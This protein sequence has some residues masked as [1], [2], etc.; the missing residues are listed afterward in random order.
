MFLISDPTLTT[1]NV[2]QVMELVNEWRSLSYGVFR[3]EVIIP[4]SQMSDI[5]Q[6]SST[7]S[8]ISTECAFHYVHCHPE[9]SWTHLARHLYDRGEIAAVEKLKPFLPLRGKYQVINYAGMNHALHASTVYVF[10]D[11]LHNVRMMIIGSQSGLHIDV[12]RCTDIWPVMY[13]S[14]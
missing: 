7:K 4:S 11:G 8:E 2:A 9:P 12:F 6:K 10:C 14:D 13:R 1:D 5:Q 3:T